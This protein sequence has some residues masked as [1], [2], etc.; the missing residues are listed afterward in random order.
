MKGIVIVLL[1]MSI[2][3]FVMVESEA[4]LWNL[5]IEADVI[6][7]AA[8]GGDIVIAGIVVDHASRAVK[9]TVQIN[10]GEYSLTSETNIDGQFEMVI[11]NSNLLPGTHKALIRTVSEND[12][13]GLANI[14]V[15]IQ[16]DYRPS[17][18]TA[19]MLATTEALKYLSA[20]ESDFEENSINAKLYKYYQ[21]LQQ[22]RIMQYEKEM[23]IENERRNMEHVHKEQAIILEKLLKTQTTSTIINSHAR[24]VFLESLDDVQREIFIAQQKHTLEIQKSLGEAIR[25]NTNQNTASS[26]IKHSAEFAIP[27]H[28][29]ETF[30]PTT[31]LDI[32]NYVT[33]TPATNSEIIQGEPELI[34]DEPESSSITDV[35]SG[36]GITTVY[37]NVD[38]VMTKHIFDGTRLV[39]A[40]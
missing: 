33:V 31:A 12:L 22:D 34:R 28:V 3:P 17:D 16:G 1:I 2:S 39:V 24:Q 11:K 36:A 32:N 18:H 30:T 38:G 5:L 40:E 9:S 25:N 13:I 7:E 15:V 19:R 4:K 8:Y 21:K 37:L 14:P 29:M 35:V 20:N 6:G 23:I 26:I 10:V 27:R